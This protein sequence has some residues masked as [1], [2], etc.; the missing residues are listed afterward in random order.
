MPPCQRYP[1]VPWLAQTGAQ[2]LTFLQ[3]SSLDR[4]SLGNDNQTFKL[5]TT[6]SLLTL[7]ILKGPVWFFCFGIPLGRFFMRSEV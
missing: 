5:Y 6:M 4:I 2:N 7:C 3:T 1:Q